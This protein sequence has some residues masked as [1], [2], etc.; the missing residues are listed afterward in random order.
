M[1]RCK[2]YLPYVRRACSRDRSESIRV[3]F[4]MAF[5]QQTG[6]DFFVMVQRGFP[7][8]VIE[9]G[10]TKRDVESSPLVVAFGTMTFRRWARCIQKRAVGVKPK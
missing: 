8:L 1:R 6:R 3:A 5:Y 2:R 10:R 7:H 4:R 9:C